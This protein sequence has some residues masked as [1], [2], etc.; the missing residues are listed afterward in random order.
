V[1]FI[2]HYLDNYI[3]LGVPGSDQCWS[4]L[5]IVE[6]ECKRLGVPLAANKREGPSTCLTFLEYRWTQW[7][8]SYCPETN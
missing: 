4:L 5:E 1:E 6:K 7:L 8:A 2:D 3:I